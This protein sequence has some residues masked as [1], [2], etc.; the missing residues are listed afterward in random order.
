MPFLQKE[1]YYFWELVLPLEQHVRTGKKF[2]TPPSLLI[3]V[4]AA[5][6]NEMMSPTHNRMMPPVITR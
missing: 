3:P 4:E 2:Q 6:Q 1:Q 5:H